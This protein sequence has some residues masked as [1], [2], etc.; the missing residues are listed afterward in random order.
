MVDCEE[1]PLTWPMLDARL[2]FAVRQV[3]FTLM[4]SKW[5]AEAKMLSY[6][7]SF[8][9]YTYMSSTTSHIL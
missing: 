8:E 9:E 1:R 6:I 2:S 4:C 7:T 5:L 3:C